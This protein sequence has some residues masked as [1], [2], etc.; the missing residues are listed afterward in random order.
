MAKYS[1][2]PVVFP[3]APTTTPY[4]PPVVVVQPRPSNNPSYTPAKI[5][6]PKQPSSFNPAAVNFPKRAASV[7]RPAK[8][9]VKVASAYDAKSDSNKNGW[10]LPKFY[11]EVDLGMNVNIGFQTCDGL[12]SSIEPYEFRDGNSTDFFKQKRP[13]M[14]SFG[15]ITLKKGMFA[16]DTALYKWYKNVSTG[17]LF[18]DMRTVKIRLKDERE[19]T[20]YTWT[21]KKAFVVKYAPTAMDAHDDGEVAVEELEIACQSWELESGGPGLLGM[22]TS[23][24]SGVLGT[25]AG[26]VSGSVAG[27]V[28]RI[29]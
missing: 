12:E 24:A 10:A 16:S 17:A 4:A 14:V 19:S 27:I 1:P 13:G 7:F 20:L 8:Q 9:S 6:M 3:K 25:V 2:P 26:A 15:N 21:L 22:L 29:F 11:F 28:G 5:N 18:G 23:S